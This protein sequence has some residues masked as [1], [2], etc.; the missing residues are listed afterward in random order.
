MPRNYNLYLADML[1]ASG[2]VLSYV[3]A[4]QYK[5]L[6]D[7]RMRLDAI[8]RNLEIIGEAAS[9]IPDEIRGK[10]PHV[11]WR[12]IAN[13]RNVLAH[14]YFGID[15]EIMWNIIQQKIPVLCQQLHSIVS[16]EAIATKED[17]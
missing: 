12:K 8:V 15:Y 4:L 9:K 1:E 16:S 5:E 7:D 6:L 14:E 11:E 13:F 10:Y 2:R 3:D 17:T